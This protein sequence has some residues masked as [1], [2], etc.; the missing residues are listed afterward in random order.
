MKELSAPKKR[1]FTDSGCTLY[2]KGIKDDWDE[3]EIRS[4]IKHQEGIK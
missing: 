1:K 2:I 4:L 3:A